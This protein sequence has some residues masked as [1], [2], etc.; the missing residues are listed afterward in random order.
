MTNPD[1]IPPVEPLQVSELPPRTLIGG[2]TGRVDTGVLASCGVDWLQVTV[3]DVEPL[4]LLPEWLKEAEKQPEE[5][6]G[7]VR[8][9][10]YTHCLALS[11]GG[12]LM[13]CPAKPKHGVH[14][15]LNGSEVERLRLVEP[16][17]D[18]QLLDWLRGV[19]LTRRV[20][21]TRCDLFTDLYGAG[22]AVGP[23][24]R[25]VVEK[26]VITRALPEVKMNVGAW[27]EEWTVYIGKRGSG[28]ML[29]VYDKAR[30]VA[31]KV[32]VLG[33][34]RTR[35]EVE[36]R[37]D[38][39]NA[40]LGDEL[41]HVGIARLVL[42]TAAAMVTF[43]EPWWGEV[44]ASGNDV[45]LVAVEADGERD[46]LEWLRK[47]ALRSVVKHAGRF[48]SMDLLE[49]LVEALLLATRANPAA[50]RLCASGLLH[51]WLLE[52]A[53]VSGGR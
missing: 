53:G 18:V 22:Y 42:N 40:L 5:V 19:R 8:K 48:D 24:G 49:P 34:E 15:R 29:R 33:E 35:I 10:Q 7:W 46:A 11:P 17:I 9:L 51:T 1:C 31:S 4:Q 44:V 12:F 36:F 23:L 32:G 50:R 39:A 21:L 13:W 14:L 41:S 3:H 6:P 47:M 16:W 27:G 28:K 26:R 38:Y 25:E 43:A 52:V 45:R 20:N 2:G 30:E 37:G